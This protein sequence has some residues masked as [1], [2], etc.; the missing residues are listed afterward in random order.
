MTDYQVNEDDGKIETVQS[1]KHGFFE[2][3]YGTLFNPVRTFRSISNAPPLFHGFIIFI[4]VVV[5]TSLVNMLLPQD[6]SEMPPQLAEAAVQVGPSVVIIGAIFS[7][8][9]WLVQAGIL[10]VIAELLGGRGKA[11]GVLT[12]LA[13]AGIPS[14]LVVPLRVISYLFEESLAGSFLTIV[15]SLLAFLWWIVLIVLGLREV[16]G[17]S[18]GKAVATVVAPLVGIL[19]IIIVTAISL[20]AFIAPLIESMQ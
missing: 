11:V 6:L 9:L 4:S 15:G 17:F 18:T 12:I 19:L 8:V 10:Q 5:V 1:E 20:F 14:V 16:Q 13:L 3:I 2:L 7:L